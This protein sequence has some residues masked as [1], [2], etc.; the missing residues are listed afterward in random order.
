M[1]RIPSHFQS[2]LWSYDISKLDKNR[3]SNLIITQLLNYGG[4][5]GEK[6]ILS[7]Y[8][9][10]KIEEVLIHPRRGVWERGTLRKWLRYF[11]ITID[12]LEFEAAIRDFSSPQSLINEVWKR[13]LSDSNGLLRQNS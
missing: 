3:N 6:W 2:A 8:P 9:K 5:K 12:P 13:K 7:N 11:D 4:K 10:E 1:N